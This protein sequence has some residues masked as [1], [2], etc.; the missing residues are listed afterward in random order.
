MPGAAAVT[1]PP[2]GRAPS[3]AGRCGWCGDTAATTR[4]RRGAPARPEA[5][6]PVRR[7]SC[8]DGVVPERALAQQGAGLRWPPGMRFVDVHAAD[9]VDCRFEDPPRLLDDVLA[10]EAPGVPQD[11]VVEQSLVRLAP[12]AER[13]REVDGQIDRLAVDLIARN[14]GLHGKGDAVVGAETEPDQVA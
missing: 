9:L 7:R 14:L 8:R 2:A 3:A 1:P 6:P 4:S 5:G 11:G 10:R 13:R 12:F